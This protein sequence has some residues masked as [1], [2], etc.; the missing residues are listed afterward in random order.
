MRSRQY[1]VVLSRGR[2]ANGQGERSDEEEMKE[3]FGFIPLAVV[4][5]PYL[6]AT[7]R[8]AL[9]YKG[10]M[11]GFG[12]V[13]VAMAAFVIGG[14]L[15]ITYLLFV[16]VTHRTYFIYERRRPH[17][18]AMIAFIAGLCLLVT[19]SIVVGGIAWQKLQ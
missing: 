1:L 2:L 9:F 6:V 5:V 15:N 16:A 13:L 17:I 12:Y 14:V 7:I 18:I 19:Q 4:V 3:Y 8:Q 11:D 10:C